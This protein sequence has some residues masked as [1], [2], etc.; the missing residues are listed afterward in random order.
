[1]IIE[2]M[3]KKKSILSVM[4]VV[5]AVLQLATVL[6]SWIVSSAIPS[7]PCRS[8]L[9]SEGIRWF[10]GSFVDNVSSPLLV[11]LILFVMAYGTFTHSRFKEVFAL[12]GIAD[13]RQ[14]HAF[15]VALTVAVVIL[16]VVVA[17]SFV[18]H[19]VLLGVSG[20]LYPSAFSS[21]IVPVCAFIVVAS[22]ISYG[23]ACGRY[24]DIN[25]IFEGLYVGFYKLSSLF[26]I[27]I[28]AVQ[29]YYSIRY[30]LII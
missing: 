16:I 10:M 8:M 21:A 4:A 25:E 30:V 1:M 18:P 5:L 28:L 11:W 9:S 26:P 23:V 2:F 20:S 6:F 12:N 3:Y 27:Y 19:A 24:S 15:Y 14:R 7:L 29:L 22:S 13:Y 17:L